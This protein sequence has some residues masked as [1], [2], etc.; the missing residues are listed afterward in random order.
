MAMDS[1]RLSV[2][3]NRL[4]TT[5]D[6]A[7]SGLVRSCY[8]QV[9]RDYHDYCTGIFDTKGQM[10]AHSTR[11][12]C[13]FIGVIGEVMKHFIAEFKDDIR[14][15][16]IYI[17]NDP[18]LASGHLLDITVASPIF[19]QGKHVG[20]ALCIVHHS[21]IGGRRAD[22]DARDIYEEGIQIPLLK[23]FNEGKEDK[24]ISAMI[25]ANVRT[26]HEVDGDLRAQLSALFICEKGVQKLLEDY[27]NE[28]MEGIAD[29]II[30]RSEESMRAAIKQIPPG[31]YRDSLHLPPHGKHPHPIPLV[32]T[33]TVSEFEIDMDLTGSSGEVLAAVNSPL[34]FTKGYAFYALK[35]L[36]DPHIPNNSG[37][38]RPFRFICPEGSILNCRRPAPTWGR[39][40]IGHSLP[41]LVFG[42]LRK[43]IPDRL[44]ADCGS[45]PISGIY[46]R[47]TRYTGA[48]FLAL[49]SD[50]GGYGAGKGAD[51]KACISFPYNTAAIPIEV[52]EN[53]TALVFIR[54]EMATDSGG[55][56]E[57]RG[58]LGQVVEFKIAEAPIAPPTEV[59]ISVRG[60]QRGETSVYP[61][62]GLAGGK[63][64]RGDSLTLN[65]GSYS[66]GSTNYLKPGD[67]FCLTLPGGGGYGDS[68][69]RLPESVLEDVREQLVSVESARDEYGVAI[70]V[71]QM[72]VDV[73]KT[74]QLRSAKIESAAE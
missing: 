5:V 11:T 51:G 44:I 38:I 42:A 70:D 73:A 62:R 36:L 72:K 49:Q 69:A 24:S 39:A 60:A 65:G 16:D 35:L 8:S 52:T 47:G 53:E 28:T 33:L 57:W 23:F 7:A 74:R 43:V 29:S 13:G 66:Q 4:I 30:S 64:G 2:I 21:D 6:E 22:I 14:P 71:A 63:S 9:V 59:L 45:T 26:P 46:S 61:I 1:I 50:R 48:P 40:V 58:G 18:W 25:R 34:Y 31:V 3:W 12:T 15:G 19:Q 54:K 56:G 17:T 68:F 27:P 55:P 20:Y 10:L 41:E 37:C 67:T 32:M